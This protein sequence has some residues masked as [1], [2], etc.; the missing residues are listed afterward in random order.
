MAVDVLAI[1]PDRRA[2]LERVLPEILAA[3]R[4]ALS[5]HINSDGDGCGSESALAQVLMQRGIDV[6]IVN[7]TP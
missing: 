2:A 3:Q 1:P 5:T 6:R 4:V 7:P